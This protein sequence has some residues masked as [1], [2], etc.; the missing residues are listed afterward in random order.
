MIGRAVELLMAMIQLVLPKTTWTRA[1]IRRIVRYG[2]KAV[3]GGRPLSAKSGHSP[4]VAE[5]P[6]PSTSFDHTVGAQSGRPLK[7]LADLNHV[8]LID[9]GSGRLL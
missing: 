8:H 5:L 2:S 6:N 7:T 4:T 9:D 3:T 1:T